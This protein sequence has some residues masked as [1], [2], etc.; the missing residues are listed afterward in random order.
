M[1]I[2]VCIRASDSRLNCLNGIILFISYSRL[3][4]LRSIS[5]VYSLEVFFNLLSDSFAE[6][7]KDAVPLSIGAIGT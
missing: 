2:K 3:K 5:P 4:L 1:F 6:E 7:K